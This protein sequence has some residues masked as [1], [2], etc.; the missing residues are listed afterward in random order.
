MV[1]DHADN[2][3]LTGPEFIQRKRLISHCGPH[4][5]RSRLGQK[6]TRSVLSQ[7]YE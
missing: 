4:R 7:I 5:F 6:D 2:T 3:F 1:E